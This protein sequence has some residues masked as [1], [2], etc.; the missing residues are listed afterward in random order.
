MPGRKAI[1]KREHLAFVKVFIAN[2]ALRMAE[3]GASAFGA[4]QFDSF[5]QNDGQHLI[6]IR[7]CGKFLRQI[8]AHT[9]SGIQHRGFSLQI[10]NVPETLSV[11]AQ[12]RV[13]V[14]GNNQSVRGANP[15]KGLAEF[16]AVKFTQGI[17]AAKRER[18][19]I[20]H[21]I[22]K[23]FELNRGFEFATFPKK[24]DHF[25]KRSDGAVIGLSGGLG[26]RENPTHHR[27][28]TSRIRHTIHHEFG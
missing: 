25:P 14:A 6:G 18:M 16:L 11:I 28:E 22:P 13:L 27:F 19:R 4:D 23:F 8:V 2:Q 17:G 15:R 26:L 21:G 3:P 5:S 20:G 9:Y 12:G 7:R 10:S 24:G 1:L